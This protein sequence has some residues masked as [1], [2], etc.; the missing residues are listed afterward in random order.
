MKR[1]TKRPTRVSCLASLHGPERFDLEGVAFADAFRGVESGGTN[2]GDLVLEKP[3]LNPL[4]IDV[5]TSSVRTHNRN[6]CG[7]PQLPGGC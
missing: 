2:L 5:R 4:E 1:A 7:E 3:I 6:N